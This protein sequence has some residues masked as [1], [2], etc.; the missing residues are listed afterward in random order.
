MP[1]DSNFDAAGMPPK[2]GEKKSKGGTIALVIILVLLAAVV[3]VIALDIGN[4]RS[5]HIMGFVRNAPLVGSLFPAEEEEDEYAYEEMTEEELRDELRRVRHEMEGLQERF[6]ARNAELTT[7]NARI[8]HLTRF[9]RSW[10]QY[11]ETAARFTEMLAQNV[12]MQFEEFFQDIVDYDLVPQDILAGAFAR[13]QAINISDA[14]F[15]LIVRTYNSREAGRVA[16]DLERLLRDNQPLALRI[17]RSLNNNQR[18][19]VLDEMEYTVSARFTDLISTSPPTFP[20][21]VAAPYLPEFVAPE[22]PPPTPPVTETEPE[23]ETEQDVETEPIEETEQDE[24][25]EPE[26]EAEKSEPEEE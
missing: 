18:V 1:P 24:E 20:P 25:T 10:Q 22:I 6:D 21:L 17:M 11:R 7:A 26:E 16:E 12:P 14:E 3:A 23:E 19:E 4:V 5:Q 13:A 2:D 8:D 9:E 15:E